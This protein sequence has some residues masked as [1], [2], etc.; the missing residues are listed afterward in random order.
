MMELAVTLFLFFFFSCCRVTRLNAVETEDYRADGFGC[1]P[2]VLTTVS[3]FSPPT[4]R[5]TEGEGNRGSEETL[6]LLDQI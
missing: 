4:H 1:R 2:C 5:R 3:P 6:K